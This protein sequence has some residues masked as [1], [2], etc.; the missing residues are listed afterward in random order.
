MFEACFQFHSCISLALRV[1][2]FLIKQHL[3]SQVL[4]CSKCHLETFSKEGVQRVV[5]RKCPIKGIEGPSVFAFYLSWKSCR[6]GPGKGWL[7]RQGLE[8]A[9]PRQQTWA[10]KPEAGYLGRTLFLSW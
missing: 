5:G 10:E 9:G 2:R 4:I 6:P 7:T 8:G 1:Q 3:S